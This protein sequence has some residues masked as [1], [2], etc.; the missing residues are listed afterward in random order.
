MTSS[1]PAEPMVFIPMQDWVAILFTPTL[2]EQI[3]E[4]EARE[5]ITY[6]QATGLPN[7][8]PAA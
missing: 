5:G 6:E 4:A 3:A 2:P 8:F 1:E 7:P